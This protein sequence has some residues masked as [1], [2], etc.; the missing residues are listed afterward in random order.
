[1]DQALYTAQ[2]LL[3]Q[4]PL[5]VV[6]ILILWCA[7]VVYDIT[8]K[9]SFDEELVEKDNSAVGVSLAGYLLGIGFALK[10]VFAGMVANPEPVLIENDEGTLIEVAA[11]S[12][13]PS[14]AS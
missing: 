9:Y 4:L 11:S 10:G 13:S 2:S 14:T 3:D 1:M 6:A 8:T 12:T 5:F 7:K